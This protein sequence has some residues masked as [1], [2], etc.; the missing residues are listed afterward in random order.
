MWSPPKNV[1]FKIKVQGHT[2]KKNPKT[3]STN[4]WER[5]NYLLREKQ[6][7]NN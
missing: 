5:E 3:K 1:T 7:K 4:I 6:Q 2:F